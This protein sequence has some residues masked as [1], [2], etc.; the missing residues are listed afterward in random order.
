[1]NLK[2]LRVERIVF[3]A[4]GQKDGEMMNVQ[5]VKCE[6]E[7]ITDKI[8]IEA[9]CI[10]KINSQ[11]S[12][13][14]GRYILYKY[15]PHLQGLNIANSS[16]KTSFDVDLLVGI[17]FCYNFITSNVKRGP[18]GEPVA[19]ESKLGLVLTGPLKSNF[20]QRYLCDTHIF[21]NKPQY[22]TFDETSNLNFP[23][24]FCDTESINISKKD[25]LFYV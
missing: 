24:P 16:S 21:H 22:Q 15:Y 11:L 18:I 1:M 3:N 10:P 9:L 7:M 8:F 14:K 12:N 6:V 20:V 13:Q 5:I 4:F 17:D 23:S 25:K 2:P 19:I